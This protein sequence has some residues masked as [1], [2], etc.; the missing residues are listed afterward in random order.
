MLP[1]GV[2]IRQGAGQRVGRRAGKGASLA[3][4]L[5]LGVFC[6][7]LFARGTVCVR[8]VLRA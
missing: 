1:G 3:G 7:A 4:L 2:R 8:R 6:R 5:R